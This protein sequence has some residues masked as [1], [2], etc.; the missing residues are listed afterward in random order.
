MKRDDEGKL[1]YWG[2]TEDF[3]G[4]ERLVLAKETG[5]RSP[6]LEDKDREVYSVNVSWPQGQRDRW[7]DATAAR[8]K[9][10]KMKEETLK[11]I[12]GNGG[13]PSLQFDMETKPT[14]S[15]TP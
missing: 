10:R 4:L 11:E 3:C 12:G 9:D 6:M 8:Y 15:Q 5:G 1:R 14:E 2:F 7:N 13:R